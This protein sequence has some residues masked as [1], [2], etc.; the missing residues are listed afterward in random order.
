M[1]TTTKQ[2]RQM[3]IAIQFTAW[4]ADG[5]LINIQPDHGQ[6][7]NLFDEDGRELVTVTIANEFL[8]VSTDG[9][10]LLGD[11]DPDIENDLS[12]QMFVEQIFQATGL[13]LDTSMPPSID[14]Q[15]DWTN[16]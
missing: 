8:F 2:P 3:S 1:K 15:L 16:G 14:M 7:F 11:H 12:L 4:T 10:D 6:Q 5:R 9:V 13:D